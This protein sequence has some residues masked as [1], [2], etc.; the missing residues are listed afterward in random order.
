M[1]PE[2]FFGSVMPVLEFIPLQRRFP[3]VWEEVRQMSFFVY[4]SEVGAFHPFH[5]FYTPLKQPVD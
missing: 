5:D 2:P 3:H 4:F 1:A